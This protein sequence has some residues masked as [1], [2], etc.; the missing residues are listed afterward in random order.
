MIKEEQEKNKSAK[1]R[2]GN[3]QKIREK[4]RKRR[5][6]IGEDRTERKKNNKSK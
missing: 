1:K 5:K 4:G 2:R 3:G 6:K